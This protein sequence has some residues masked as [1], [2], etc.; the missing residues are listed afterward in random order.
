MFRHLSLEFVDNV[1]WPGRLTHADKNNAR[2]FH[3]ITESCPQIR[4]F[5]F[6]VLSNPSYGRW[7]PNSA[8]DASRT[9]A[10]DRTA[11]ALRS[12][13]T[14]VENLSI[15]TYG[16]DDAQE[17]LRFEIAADAEWREQICE[18]WPCVTMMR[19]H[20]DRLWRHFLPMEQIQEWSTSRPARVD[21]TQEM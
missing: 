15:I 4:T 12:L 9:V 7:T 18:D 11:Q 14:C 8:N 6:Y 20:R 5:A 16:R 3:S 21:R 19:R 2:L 17:E 1:N 10:S 13:R